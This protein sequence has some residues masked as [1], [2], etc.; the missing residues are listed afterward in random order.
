[1]GRA[2]T[3][4]TLGVALSAIVI[5]STACAD[6]P[7]LD[8]QTVVDVAS[9]GVE[10]TG[11]GPAPGFGAGA[12]V[13]TDIVATGAHVVAGAETITLHDD[14]GNEHD[15]ELVALD[16]EQDVALLSTTDLDIA[17]LPIGDAEAGAPTSFLGFRDGERAVREATV[18]RRV[19]ISTG[20]IYRNGDVDRPG[21]QLSASIDDG[22]SGGVLVD[23]DGDAVGVIWSRS[24]REETRGWAMRMDPVRELIDGVDAGLT[25]DPLEFSCAPG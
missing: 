20:D 10:V 14:D 13:A 1:M 23:D 6:E 22:D 3:L 15:G 19:N 24:T 12:V 25:D 8:R 9:L 21:Y 2:R 16:P 11:C 5:A 17:P 7:E 4:S 18:T